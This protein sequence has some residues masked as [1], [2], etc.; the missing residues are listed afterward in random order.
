M[1][2]K[3]KRRGWRIRLLILTLLLGGSV[4]CSTKRV[5]TEVVCPQPSRE[6]F[7]SYADLVDSWQYRPHSRYHARLIGY[8]FPQTP[9]I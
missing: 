5:S 3:A 4:S 6:E 2:G 9:S 8:C 1:R 7:E